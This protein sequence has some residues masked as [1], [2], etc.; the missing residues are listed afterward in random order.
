VPVGARLGLRI[1]GKGGRVSGDPIDLE[2][3]VTAIVDVLY[4]TGFGGGRALLGNAVAVRASRGAIGRVSPTRSA[5][6]AKVMHRLGTPDRKP[7]AD[8]K[9]FSR[10][11]KD[12]PA[13]TNGEMS[14]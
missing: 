11:P 1:G 4:Q 7:A 6:S 14:R 12:H 13:V 3:T 8:R 2:I 5:N 9:T 10:N